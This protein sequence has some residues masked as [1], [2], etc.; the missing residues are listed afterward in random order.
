MPSLRTCWS[1]TYP[2]SSSCSF[3]LAPF[4]S[5]NGPFASPLNVFAKLSAPQ[6][7]LQLW[8]LTRRIGPTLGLGL[9]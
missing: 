5:R 6:E 2:A 3:E 4:G 7:E 8:R 1:G 9:P